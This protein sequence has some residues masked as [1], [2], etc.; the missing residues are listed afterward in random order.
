MVQDKIK[1]RTIY[2]MRGM[3][4]RLDSINVPTS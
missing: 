1:E 2:Y 4:G 3:L